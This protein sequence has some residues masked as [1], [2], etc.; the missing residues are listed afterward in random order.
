VRSAEAHYPKIDYTKAAEAVENLGNVGGMGVLRDTGEQ[1]EE[2][3][4]GKCY[5]LNFIVSFALPSLHC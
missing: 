3:K 5:L 1:T 2:K 4:K